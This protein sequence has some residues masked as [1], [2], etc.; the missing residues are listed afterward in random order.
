MRYLAIIGAVFLAVVL[1][2]CEEGEAIE[3]DPGTSEDINLVVTSPN[4]GTAGLTASVR[5]TVT[6]DGVPVA[7]VSVTFSGTNGSQQNR[8]PSLSPVQTSILGF[9]DTDFATLRAD[10]ELIITA[11]V[12]STSDTVNLVL[13]PAP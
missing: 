9:A 11:T 6:V 1:T 2:G 13:E 5:A 7:A 10:R 3:I 8:P 12:G 4:P